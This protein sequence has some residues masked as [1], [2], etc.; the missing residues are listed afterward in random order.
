MNNRPNIIEGTSVMCLLSGTKRTGTVFIPPQL[1]M[2]NYMAHAEAN[3]GKLLYISEFHIQK[4]ALKSDHLIVWTNVGDRKI[5]GDIVKVGSNYDPN[6]PP[7]DNAYTPCFPYGQAPAKTWV[8]L[9]NVRWLTDFDPSRYEVFSGVN[10]PEPL[11]D[12]FSHGTRGA[13]ASKDGKRTQYR[14][15]PRSKFM[16]IRPLAPTKEHHG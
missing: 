7:M 9:E 5:I 1:L 11:A 15:V 8:A 13:S 4:R 6:D 3:D 12:R 2:H 10:E 16:A 14:T